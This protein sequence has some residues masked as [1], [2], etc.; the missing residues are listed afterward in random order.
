MGKTRRE[1]V[2]DAVQ[3]A[4]P[5][6]LESFFVALAGAALATVLGTVVAFVMSVRS[7][8][9]D[10]SYV[11]IPLILREKIRCT[12]E[13]LWNIVHLVDYRSI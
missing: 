7:L 4:W 9:L 2:M 1:M 8:F 6:V 12:R 13:A 5:S 3:M 11:S 10:K